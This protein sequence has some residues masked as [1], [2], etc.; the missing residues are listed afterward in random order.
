MAKDFSYWQKKA[1]EL[2]EAEM[3]SELNS[4]YSKQNFDNLFKHKLKANE[5]GRFGGLAPIWAEFKLTGLIGWC[6]P[7]YKDNIN[8]SLGLL[9]YGRGYK[10]RANDYWRKVENK[11]MLQTLWTDIP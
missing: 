8:Y 6:N 5:L 10:E 7:K 11:S 1:K 4:Y 2:T 3:L 9:F